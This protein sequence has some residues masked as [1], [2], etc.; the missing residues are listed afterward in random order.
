MESNAKYWWWCISAV[1][2]I[3]GLAAWWI[4]PYGPLLLFVGIDW[5]VTA[6][7][8][9]R[10]GMRGEAVPGVALLWLVLG[11]LSGIAMTFFVLGW[12]V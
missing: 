12:I 8:G 1:F 4:W 6:V 11:G 10:A 2:G 7:F 3:I 5:A 9:I